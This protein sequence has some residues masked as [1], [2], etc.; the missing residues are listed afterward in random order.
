VVQPCSVTDL[1]LDTGCGRG[2]DTEYDK[3]GMLTERIG[4]CASH[5]LACVLSCF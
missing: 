2:K 4:L 1:V 3:F 5:T